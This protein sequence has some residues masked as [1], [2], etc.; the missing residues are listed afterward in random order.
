MKPT[1]LQ[2]V[3]PSDLTRE[4]LTDTPQ[5]WEDGLRA[6]TGPG[7][8]EWWYFDAHLDD[9]STA[10]VVFMTKPLLQ[11]RDPLTPALQIT[12]TRPD[13]TRLTQPATFAPAEFQA[14]KDRCDVRIG[15][16]HIQGDLHS[17]DLHAQAGEL[18]AD[19]RF[20]GSVPPWRPGAGKTFYSE[21]RSRYFAWLP[22]IPYGTVEGT[23]VYD[24]AAHAV[25][26]VCYHDHN[27]GNVD[28]NRVMSH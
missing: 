16:N 24:G 2:G 13:G 19:L 28:L 22:A 8:F 6:D 10:V 15:Q 23:L 20:I 17:Y 4:G 26:G 1:I 25:Q 12:I 7:N 5:P 27:W 3:D 18:K 11:R 21:D 9:G 14:G